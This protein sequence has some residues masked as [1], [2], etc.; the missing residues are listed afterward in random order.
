M[1]GSRFG[2]ML[3]GEISQCITVTK[4]AVQGHFYTDT[5]EILQISDRLNYWTY[6][7]SSGSWARLWK[8][9]EVFWTVDKDAL[10]YHKELW[11]GT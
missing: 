11:S 10:V 1:G 8:I 2:N 9:W 3:Y 5:V 7:V 4:P 6:L